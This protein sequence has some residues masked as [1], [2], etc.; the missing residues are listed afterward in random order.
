MDKDSLEL[1]DHTRIP[2]TE[3]P[4]SHTQESPPSPT[5]TETPSPAFLPPHKTPHEQHPRQVENSKPPQPH[6]RDPE[7]SQGWLA[8]PAAL[9]CHSLQRCTPPRRWCWGTAASATAGARA[10]GQTELSSVFLSPP[11]P[12]IPTWNCPSAPTAATALPCLSQLLLSALTE[13]FGL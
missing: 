1:R 5:N 3:A 9:T 2:C 11:H 13:V 12:H 7:V 4:C 8:E 6:P 10:V